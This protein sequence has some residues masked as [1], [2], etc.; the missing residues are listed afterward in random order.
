MLDDFRVGRSF[1]RPRLGVSTVY[2]AGDFAEAL[3]LPSRGGLLIQEVARGSAAAASGL[4]GASQAVVIGNQQLGVGGDL[5][6]AI[7]GKAVEE[8]D[9]VTRAIARK[10]PGDII[11][12]ALVRGGRSLNVRVKLGEAPEERF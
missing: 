2:V 7:D 1:G 3:K 6:T 12:L 5:I 9:A 8:P 11:D 10:R 4:R